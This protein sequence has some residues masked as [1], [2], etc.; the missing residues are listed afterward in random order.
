MFFLSSILIPMK[1]SKE[2]QN[3]IDFKINEMLNKI[4]MEYPKN[5]L[6]EIINKL[7]IEAY[8]V[9]F[10]DAADYI[11]GI[12]DRE[13]KNKPKIYLNEKHSRETQTFTL[14]HELGHYFLHD[15]ATNYRIDSYNHKEDNEE[16][17]A[18]YFAASLLMPEDKLRNI[19][20]ETKNIP[21]IAEYFGVSTS[22]IKSRINWM[23]MN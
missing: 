21:A 3:E 11:S 9:D 5:S 22:A 20:K 19:L 7:S 15:G 12:I 6:L 18:D 17:E 16:T 14:A 8:T 13:Q 10:G 4:G 23:K 1:L 2:R